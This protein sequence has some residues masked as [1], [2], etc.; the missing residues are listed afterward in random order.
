MNPII[1]RT[2]AAA[3]VA[4][5]GLA[6][7]PEPETHK[8]LSN[9][10]QRCAQAL[11]YFITQI[12]KIDSGRHQVT[13]GEAHRP[14][15]VA[16]HYA[17]QGLGIANSLHVSRLAIDLNLFVDGEY[18]TTTEA[19]KPLAE[20]WLEIG[21][22]FGIVPAAGFFFKDGNHYSCAWEGRK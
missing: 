14:S 21:P 8:S 18:Q 6:S 4:A 1:V 17:R 9:Y 13:Y 22:H 3:A 16:A 15:W 2:I 20:L 19:H 7:L 11:S 5:A 12:P 10:Q